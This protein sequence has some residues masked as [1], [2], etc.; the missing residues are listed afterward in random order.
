MKRLLTGTI[1]AVLVTVAIFALP[2]AWFF[3]LCVGVMELAA[4]E[5]IRIGR[6]WAPRA[7]LWLLLVLVPVASAAMGLLLPLLADPPFSRLVIAILALGLVYVIAV[8][9]LWARTPVE[10]ALPAI[11]ILSF[12][13]PYL[14]LPAVSL[15]GIRD[16]DPWLLVLLLAI[17]WIGDSAAY[18]GGSTLG[19]RKLAPRVSP[20]KTLEGALAGLVGSLVACLVWSLWRLDR[21]DP[22]LLGLAGLCA[23]AAQVGDLVESM[24]KRGADV[25]DSGTLL[26]GHGGALDRL[27]A[28]LFSAPL[29]FAVLLVVGAERFSP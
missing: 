5:L 7:P 3:W 22:G 29:F 13:V 2:G 27:D 6:H 9:V 25:K 20:N 28:L 17:V 10:Q 8:V 21:V 18:Y 26:P 19:R 14:A 12:G 16:A 4:L 11:G 15:S 24:M 1:G 23:I